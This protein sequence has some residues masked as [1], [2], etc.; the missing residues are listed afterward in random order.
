MRITF[1][2]AVSK[3]AL[4]LARDCNLITLA[5]PSIQRSRMLPN[6]PIDS[7]TSA[8]RKFLANIPRVYIETLL[9]SVS[10]FE[11]AFSVA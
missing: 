5:A 9:A 1:D 7:I 6:I 4:E 11:V 2:K 3:P 10:V 8:L